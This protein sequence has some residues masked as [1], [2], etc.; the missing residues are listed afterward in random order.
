MNVVIP[1]KTDS[2]NGLELRYA[3]RSLIKHFIGFSGVCLIGDKPEWYMGEHIIAYDIKNRKELSIVSKVMLSPYED[4]LLSADDVFAL[5]SFDSSLPN[6]CSGLLKD[7]RPVG[8]YVRRRNNTLH[9]YPNGFDYDIH[10]PIVI[11]LSKF[12]ECNKVDWARNE[13]L[14]KSLYGN[15][16]GGGEQLKDY[17]IR[18]KEVIDQSRPF[19][20][21]S[22]YVC[23]LLNLETLY[24]EKSEHEGD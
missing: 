5:N 2:F 12:K 4:F 7:S 17:K 11:N 3:I 16:V 18:Q 8:E 13:Y 6:Y 10:T 20:S 19:F 1:Y 14:S 15:F 22:G 9:I 23:N 24:P 21:T